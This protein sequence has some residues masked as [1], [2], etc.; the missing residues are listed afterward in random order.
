MPR[1]KRTAPQAATNMGRPLQVIEK[2]DTARPGRGPETFLGFLGFCSV[3]KRPGLGEHLRS[4]VQGQGPGG[5][6]GVDVAIGRR[7]RQQLHRGVCGA[8]PG[9][10]GCSG[11]GEGSGVLW[12]ASQHPNCLAVLVETPWAPWPLCDRCL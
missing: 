9:R 1:Q 12:A 5:V 4:C 6:E 2:N 8:A 10:E 3:L 11:A 7:R